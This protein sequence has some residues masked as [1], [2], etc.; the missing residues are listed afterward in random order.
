MTHVNG[1]A[2]HA[3]LDR[4]ERE[5]RLLKRAAAC[6]FALGLTVVL[7]AQ[8]RGGRTIVAERLVLR[9]AQGVEHGVF[10]VTPDGA[11]RLRL[12][13]PDGVG[14]AELQ[15]SRAGHASLALSGNYGPTAPTLRLDVS[16]DDFTGMY[17][18][19]G[20]GAE[21]VSLGAVEGKPAM[22]EWTQVDAAVGTRARLSGAAVL[23]LLRIDLSRAGMQ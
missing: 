9:D 10:E 12:A 3:R 2:L 7:T 21:G 19:V 13:A 11:A 5:N 23:N 17:V 6:L 22:L 1:G 15:V 18:E 8:A 14:A 4:L 16:P 20:N